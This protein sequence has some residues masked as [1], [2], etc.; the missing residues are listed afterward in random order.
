MTYVSSDGFEPPSFAI[1]AR[2]SNQLSYDD[3]RGLTSRSIRML[4]SLRTSPYPV[5][6]SLGASGPSDIRRGR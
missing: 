3:K 6:I 2:C 1:S 4:S 5:M